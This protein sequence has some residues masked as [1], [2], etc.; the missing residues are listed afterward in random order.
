MC[1]SPPYTPPGCD[2]LN[3][4]L[5]LGDMDI[6]TEEPFYYWSASDLSPNEIFTVSITAVNGNGA[7]NETFANFTT[8]IGKHYILNLNMEI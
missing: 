7:S 6:N 5:Q 4:T 2:I 8:A 1:W 3:Y